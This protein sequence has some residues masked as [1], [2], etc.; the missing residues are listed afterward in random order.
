[1]AF[2]LQGLSRVST[3]ANSDSVILWGYKSS[4]DNLATIGASAYFAS[5]STKAAI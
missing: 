3:S 4:T 2:E 1:M 5:L